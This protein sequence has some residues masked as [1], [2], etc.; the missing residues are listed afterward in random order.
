MA[1]L[2]AI[3]AVVLLA[4]VTWTAWAR[5]VRNRFDDQALPEDP[6][7]ATL[8]PHDAGELAAI[9]RR[10]ESEFAATSPNVLH[11]RLNQLLARKVPIRAVR[12]AGAAGLAQ[13][14]FADGVVIVVR[15]RRQG[16]L[17]KLAVSALR[18]PIRLA[19]VH[20]EAPGIVLDLDSNAGRTSVLAVS[21]VA[22]E[23]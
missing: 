13:M 8:D 10:V 22:T 12:S 20:D 7:V 14:C 4:H 15:G 16:D 21:V 17:A 19:S 3:A 18:F 5:L 23:S 1:E 11:A 6:L 2:I 9:A